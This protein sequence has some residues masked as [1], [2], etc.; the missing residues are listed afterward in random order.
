MKKFILLILL[1][2]SPLLANTQANPFLHGDNFPKGY[3]LIPNAMPQFM[4]IYMK[5][6]GSLDLEDLSEKQEE[7]IEAKFASTPPKIMK[8]AKEIKI[9]ESEVV[10]A[11]M[12]E[13]KDAKALDAKLDSIAQKRKAMTIFKI[14]CLN[15]FKQTLTP[16]QFDVLKDLAIKEAQQ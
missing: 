10:M 14:E 4:H 1:T 5:Q 8:L 15:M 2:L 9:L 16:K 12:N 13:G 6:G 3:F 11:V 7:I